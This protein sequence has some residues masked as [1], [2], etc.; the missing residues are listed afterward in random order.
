[1]TLLSLLDYCDAR[2]DKMRVGMSIKLDNLPSDNLHE[3]RIVMKNDFTRSERIGEDLVTVDLKG[4]D[5]F[6]N[7]F[8][9]LLE[10]AGYYIDYPKQ[11]SSPFKYALYMYLYKGDEDNPHARMKGKR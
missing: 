11:T 6:E 9:S 3:F 4:I 8:Y 10:N 5:S 1:M 2:M 7:Q